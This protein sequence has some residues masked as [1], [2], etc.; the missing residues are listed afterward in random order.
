MATHCNTKSEKIKMIPAKGGNPINIGSLF[1][2]TKEDIIAVY[3]ILEDVNLS[4]RK[5]NIDNIITLNQNFEIINVESKTLPDL[6]DD[7]KL[8]LQNDFKID[9]VP[10]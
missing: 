10:K 9:A 2:L 7:F 3:C 1:F 4:K 5:L 6:L 8:S